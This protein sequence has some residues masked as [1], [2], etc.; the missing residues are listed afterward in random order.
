[1]YGN[2]EAVLGRAIRPWREEAAVA[3]KIWTASAPDGQEQFKRQLAYFGGRVEL[4]Q[5]HNLLSWRSHLDWMERER[6]DGRIRWLG[7][8]HFS[9]SALPELERVMRTGRIQAIQVPYNPVQREIEQRILPLAA[10]MGLGVLAMR[11]FGEGGLLRGAF[12]DELRARG[13]RDWSDALLRWCLS[14]RRITAALPATASAEH[15]AANAESGN[16][17]WLDDDLRERIASL[18]R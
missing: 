11:P 15:A 7:A 10:D 16:A 4:L 9:A 6:D 1:M 8:T 3:T 12:P 5:V 17:P 2:A 13:L 14:E 18:I